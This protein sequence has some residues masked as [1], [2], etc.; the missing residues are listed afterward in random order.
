MGNGSLTCRVADS[1]LPRDAS[2]VTTGD[3]WK[4]NTAL[5]PKDVSK[6]MRVRDVGERNPHCN[7]ADSSYAVIRKDTDFDRWRITG[8]IAKDFIAV[9]THRHCVFLPTG[10]GEADGQ[11]Q[12][13]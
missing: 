12:T 3:I 1:F 6:E 2:L 7:G 10:D 11:T 5:A 9:S 8:K 13:E 4:E